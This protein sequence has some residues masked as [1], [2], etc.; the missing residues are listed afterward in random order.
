MEGLP[1]V[2]QEYSIAKTEDLYPAVG[3]GKIAPRQ[4]FSSL[5]PDLAPPQ[6]VQKQAHSPARRCQQGSRQ[7]RFADHC[8]RTGWVAR[9]SGQVLQSDPW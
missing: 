8:E 9:L 6:E 4:I 1:Q 3:F 5:F 2:L 7:I